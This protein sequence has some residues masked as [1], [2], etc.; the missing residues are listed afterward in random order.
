MTV[1]K[2]I[3]SLHFSEKQGRKQR[4]VKTRIVT[5]I[6]FFITLSDTSSQPRPASPQS[7]SQGAQVFGLR[8]GAL[9][10]LSEPFWKMHQVGMNKPVTAGQCDLQTKEK[11]MP[12]ATAFVC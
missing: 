7:E 5:A 9:E 8:M 11:Y 6:L 3:K 12:C 4:S 1:T 2:R 10:R